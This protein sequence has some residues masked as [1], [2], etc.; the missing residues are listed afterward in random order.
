MADVCTL[1]SVDLNDGSTTFVGYGVDLGYKRTE[2]DEVRSHSGAIRMIDV[3]QTLI[4]VVI[5]VKVVGT[6]GTPADA[7]YD[8]L[9][10]IKAVCVS[11]GTLTWQPS[12]ESSQV[13]TVV[14]SPEPEVKVDELYRLKHIARMELR[15]KRL[16]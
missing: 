10:D 4:D 16:P 14:M 7:L 6:G 5:P 11:G 1:G 9:V 2:F 8:K 3:H 12:G 13:F 15:L